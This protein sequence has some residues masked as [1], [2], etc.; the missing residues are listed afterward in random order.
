[1]ISNSRELAIKH[2]PYCV[3]SLPF[4]ALVRQRLAF[5]RDGT[6]VCPHCGSVISVQGHASLWI[7]LG[8]GGSGGY[9]L[10]KLLGG[11]GIGVA[12]ISLATGL[13]LFV[14]ASY[15]TA[16]IRSG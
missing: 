14:V 15:F 13:V 5:S 9:L 8:V 4:L 6:L 12:A 3:R 11:F 16:P 7:S 1:M 2:C 10:G